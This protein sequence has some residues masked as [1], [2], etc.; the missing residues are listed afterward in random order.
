M[1]AFIADVRA[2]MSTIREVRWLLPAAV[3]VE[4]VSPALT[5][6]GGT[7]LA[8]F[9]LLAPVW[10][11]LWLGWWGTERVVLARHVRGE[12]LDRRNVWTSVQV[13]GPR[14]VRLALLLLPAALPSVIAAMVWGAATWPTRG[15]TAAMVGV[16]AAT[17]TFVT[18]ALAVST[19]RARSAVVIGWR[20][21]RSSWSEVHAHV[22]V[23]A[24]TLAALALL[25]V[26]TGGIVLAVVF[27]VVGLVFRGA[28][29]RR[30]VVLVDVFW[31]EVPG[32][33]WRRRVATA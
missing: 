33:V 12:E 4:L 11:L 1:G 6:L 27:A 18:P 15:V 2:S 20:V 7:P 10:W 23:P 16:V 29:T 8:P 14:Y 26:S 13:L 32:G 3:A 22:L 31:S 30:Y 21:M 28:T 9:L 24:V 19:T 17:M 25:P 5:W